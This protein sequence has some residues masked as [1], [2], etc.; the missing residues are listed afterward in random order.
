[1]PGPHDM[2]AVDVRVSGEV[3]GVGYRFAAMRRADELDVAGWISNE[4]DGSVSAHLEGLGYRVDALL[5]W[6][7][8]GSS[9]SHVR[10]VDVTPGRIEGLEGFRA[11]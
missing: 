5:D 3:Q 1:M 11:R 9:W 8:Q 7:R 4:G 2:S 6:M 10:R